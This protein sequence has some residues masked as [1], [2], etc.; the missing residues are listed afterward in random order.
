M[1]PN[2]W[3]K[4]WGPFLWERDGKDTIEVKK[5]RFLELYEAGAKTRTIEIK[6]RMNEHDI[7]D[8][9][10]TIRTLGTSRFLMSPTTKKQYSYEVKLA[11]VKARI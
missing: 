10:D 5:R 3:T 9:C 1:V 7:I 11:A 4:N 2:S 6:L 8:W